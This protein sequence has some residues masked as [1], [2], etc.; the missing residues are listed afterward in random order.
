MGLLEKDEFKPKI[1]TSLKQLI[2]MIHKWRKDSI[3]M[4]HYDLLKLILDESGY[5][6]M[7]KNKRFRE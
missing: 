1:K 5:S 6:E 2:N 3:H 4:K 7:L